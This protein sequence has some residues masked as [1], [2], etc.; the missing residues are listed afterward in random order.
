[1]KC[2]M[3][4]NPSLLKRRS[5]TVK[6]KESGL[7]NVTLHGVEYFK[8]DRCGEE[9]F[10]YGDIEKLHQLIAGL[11]IQKKGLLTGKEIRFLRTYLGY[12]G[13]LFAKFTGYAPESISRMENGKQDIL[14]AF[15]RLVRSL[16]ANKLPDRDYDL[17]DSWLKGEGKTLRRIEIAVRDDHWIVK[18]AA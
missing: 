1:M 16:V 4:D 7:D 5:V 3:C 13:A 8:C 17:H 2:A 10:G 11:L 6:Y 9:Y 12:S 18:Q 15:D 14:K